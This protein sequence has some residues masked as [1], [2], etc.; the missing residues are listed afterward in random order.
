MVRTTWSTGVGDFDAFVLP[1]FRIRTL[2]SY[3]DGRPT[4][5]VPFDRSEAVVEGGTGLDNVSGALRWSHVLGDFDLGAAGFRG[6]VRE[7]RFGLRSGMIL[8]FYDRVTQLSA[9]AQL[10]RGAWL[11]KAEA[12]TNTGQNPKDLWSW[13]YSLGLEY[14]LYSPMSMDADL[15]IVTEFHYDDRDP[16]SFV[17]FQNDLFVGARLAM[18]D[19]S[20]TQFLGGVTFDFDDGSQVFSVE[21]SRRPGTVLYCRV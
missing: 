16:Y 9:D 15:G 14:T 11:Y 18:Y 1:G 2:S 17:L 6:I 4:L 19:V 21:A 12:M 10:T 5:P 7:P 3:S 20:D 8:P 13:A